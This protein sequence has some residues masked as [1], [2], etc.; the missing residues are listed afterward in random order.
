MIN[1]ISFLPYDK[2]ASLP[3]FYLYCYVI[4][5]E[6]FWLWGANAPFILNAI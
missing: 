6:A 5:G 3:V 4:L 1:D 2:P